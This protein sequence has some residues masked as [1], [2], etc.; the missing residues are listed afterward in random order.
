MAK[1]ILKATLGIGG[2]VAGGLPGAALGIGGGILASKLLK[3]KSA[4]GIGDPLPIGTTNPD[5]SPIPVDSKRRR[6][7][8]PTTIFDNDSRANGG[9]TGKLGG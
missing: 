7:N 6:L 1:K 3:K 2:L 8:R 9:I 5:G 4:K